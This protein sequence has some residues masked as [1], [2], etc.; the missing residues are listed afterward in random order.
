MRHRT[1]RGVED[2]EFGRD[3]SWL[4]SRL[5]VGE[6]DPLPVGRH[7]ADRQSTGE[8]PRCRDVA[9]S[10]VDADEPINLTVPNREDRGTV[11]G[12]HRVRLFPDCG[13]R[14]GGDDTD[15]VIELRQEEPRREIRR[16]RDLHTCAVSRRTRVRRTSRR[17]EETEQHCSDREPSRHARDT[18]EGT[19]W[20]RIRVALVHRGRD[21]L[22]LRERCEAFD[23]IRDAVA[24]PQQDRAGPPDRGRPEL[25]GAIEESD[26]VRADDP[27]AGRAVDV[28]IV[29]T[30]ERIDDLADRRCASGRRMRVPGA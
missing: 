23:P 21:G 19:R 29:D 27:Q 22:G 3:A 7:R 14:R 24:R 28:D 12:R 6:R 8:G 15:A 26:L 17:G 18:P 16:T 11:E 9:E 13:V 1:G 4:V 30:R 10:L 5:A 2:H 20:F 25:A